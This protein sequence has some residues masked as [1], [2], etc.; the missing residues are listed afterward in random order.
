MVYPC[1]CRNEFQDQRYG[2]GRRLHTESSKG[3]KC[4]VCGN[5]KSPTTKVLKATKEKK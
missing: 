4:T 1:N 5:R 2:A 3:D